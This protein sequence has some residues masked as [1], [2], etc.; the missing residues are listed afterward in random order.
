MDRMQG[1]DVG[2]AGFLSV[3]WVTGAV[4]V[5]LAIGA[6]VGLRLG[7]AAQVEH[8]MASSPSPMT[9]RDRPAP[10]RHAASPRIAERFD[11]SVV[12]TMGGSATLEE[13]GASVAAYGP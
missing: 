7:A 10:A 12:G 13:P 1:K 4:L 5:G 2:A 6:A 8:H 9:A 11:H 3:A